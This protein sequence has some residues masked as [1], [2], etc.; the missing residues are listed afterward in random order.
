MYSITLLLLV[1]QYQE[2]TEYV[3]RYFTPVS[4]TISGVHLICTLLL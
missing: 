4:D 3:L 2:Y 1:T